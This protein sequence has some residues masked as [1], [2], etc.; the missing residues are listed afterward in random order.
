MQRSNTAAI[1]RRFQR[2]IERMNTPAI[3]IHNIP[4]DDLLESLPEATQTNLFKFISATFGTELALDAFSRYWIGSSDYWP[5]ASVFWQIDDHGNVRSGKVMQYDPATGKRRKDGNFITWYH[6]IQPQPAA[7]ELKQCLFGEHLLKD[8]NS[9]AAIVESEKT[10]LIASIYFP[11]FIWLA[12]GSLSGLTDQRCNVLQGRK[13]YLFPDENGADKWE[14]FRN[15]SRYIQDAKLIK[16]PYKAAG[17]D[18][19][20]LLLNS[21]PTELKYILHI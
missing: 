10:A 20:D 7:F 3:R 9:P 19:A 2:D 1:E 11:A 17:E 14:A 21:T 12:C 6:K 13:V 5:G 16:L 4:T 15:D 8:S 18:L